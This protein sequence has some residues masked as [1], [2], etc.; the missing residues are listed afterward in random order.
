MANSSTALRVAMEKVD[1]LPPTR[2]TDDTSI[3]TLKSL[4][5]EPL[6]RWQDG[7]LHPALLDTWSHS[8]DG[9]HW[10]LQI[11]R[12]AR[13]HDGQPCHAEH[14]LGFLDAILESRDTF[15]MPW[16]YARYFCDTRWQ[17]DG[18]HAIEVISA[19]PIGDLLEIF[20]EFYVCRV[21]AQGDALLGTGRYR[22][23][24]W[25][26]GVAATLVAAQPGSALPVLEFL[27][28]A[29]ADERYRLLRDG[30]VQ[31]ATHLQHAHQRLDFD[32]RWEWQRQL[33][34]LSVMQYL[35]AREGLF[36]HPAARLAANHAVDAQRIV[37]E[38][39]QGLG[40]ASATVVS[41]WHT[42]YRQAAVQPIRYDPVQAQRL[43]EAIGGEARV[44]I[45][46]PLR[47]PEKALEVSQRV[48]H[49]LQQVGINGLIEVQDDRP[50][51]AREIGGK[52]MGDVA[53]F[54]SSPHSTF[55]VLSDKISSQ[56]R[57]I[58]WQGYSDP[59]VDRLISAA[60]RHPQRD[61]RHA[62]YG[63]C[64]ALLNRNPPWLYLFNPIAVLA[65]APEVAPRV[66]LGAK[67]E[68]LFNL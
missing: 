18:D 36:S 13:F 53:I 23:E 7:E 39:F 55:R 8:A 6:C 16:A 15:G 57:G 62:A 48:L 19:E 17:A 58:W 63:R 25:R 42:G 50:E 46:S 64:L 51:Y 4:V 40:H 3:L 43:L 49:A 30:V 11:R 60:A 67:G 44:V 59:Q 66:R 61:L 52:Q 34:T 45:R 65:A 22:V 2:V 37:D 33:N 54:D 1:F 26:A 12:G 24:Q 14:V 21:D 28:C 5:M 38:V 10:R 68:L 47:M 32:P 29:D 35:N 27:A 9:R 20:S 56:V 31:V 41:P